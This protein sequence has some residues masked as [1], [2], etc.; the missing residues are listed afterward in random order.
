MHG[1]VTERS[2]AAWFHAPKT[3]RNERMNPRSDR[4]KWSGEARLA[5]AMIEDAILTVRATDG[6]RTARAHRLAA[7][8]WAWLASRDASHPFAFENV[9]GY[10]GLDPGWIR[11]GLR[12]YAAR[13]TGGSVAGIGS[14][15]PRTLAT[16]ARQRIAS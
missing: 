12:D 4:G 10:L 15:M 11:R 8:A 5:L 9:C 1:L 6:V 16:N 13:R 2:R 3:R 14:A 7:E